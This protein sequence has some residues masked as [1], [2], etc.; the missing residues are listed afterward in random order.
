MVDKKALIQ[1]LSKQLKIDLE[2]HENVHLRDELVEPE[3]STP[4]KLLAV[5]EGM[6]VTEPCQVQIRQLGHYVARISL[7]GGYAVP[8]KLAVVASP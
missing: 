7:S 5:V 2:S 4:E 1:K 3:D 8:L 6:D